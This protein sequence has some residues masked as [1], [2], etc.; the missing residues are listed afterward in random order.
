VPSVTRRAAPHSLTGVSFDRGVLTSPQHG[1]ARDFGRA[2]ATLIE[3][4]RE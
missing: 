3:R 4:A 1:V 2:R